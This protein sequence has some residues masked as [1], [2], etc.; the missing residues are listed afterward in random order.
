V[1]LGGTVGVILLL[2]LVVLALREGSP[3]QEFLEW[4]PVTRTAWRGEQ[5]A[6]DVEEML[7][8]HNA[9][10]TRDGLRP[11]TLAE[12]TEAVRRRTP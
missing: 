5:D 10:R 6:I 12:Y 9:R 11:L 1:A 2:G 7:A 8:L 4:D 3:S